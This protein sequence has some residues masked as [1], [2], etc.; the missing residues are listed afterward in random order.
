MNRNLTKAELDVIQDDGAV[1]DFFDALANATRGAT[2]CICGTPINDMDDSRINHIF[3]VCL[4]ES[5]HH[6]HAALLLM[7]EGT[8]S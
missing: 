6:E 5:M 4:T 1:G 8:L 2:S 7:Q 3:E